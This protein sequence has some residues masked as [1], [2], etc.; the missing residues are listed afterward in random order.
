[1]LDAPTMLA[2]FSF[3]SLLLALVSVVVIRSIVTPMSAY[4]WTL[5][6]VFSAMSTAGGLLSGATDLLLPTP[7]G[8]GLSLLATSVFWAGVRR[9]YGA[10][11]PIVPASLI[12]A[13]GVGGPILSSVWWD[14][15][16]A[17]IIIFSAAQGTLLVLLG[18]DLILI[19]AR[20]S[21]GVWL[22]SGATLTL[23]AVLIV[24]SL[25][26]CFRIGEL[27]L[28]HFSG[29][30]GGLLL[31]RI[32]G[33]TGLYLGVILMTIDQ[34]HKRLTDKAYNDDLTELPNRRQFHERLETEWAHAVK[35]STSF[36]LLVIDLD[37]FKSINDTL[38]HAVGDTCL[39]HFARLARARLS[40]DDLIARTGGDE[41]C[42]I[43]P[44]V[45]NERAEVIADLLVESIRQCPCPAQACDVQM[46]ISVGIATWSSN[47]ASATELQALA[48]Q[49]LYL[50]K[51]RGRNDYTL[52]VPAGAPRRRSSMSNIGAQDHLRLEARSRAGRS[53]YRERTT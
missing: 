46:T 30:Q 32:C 26:A 3:N 18:L 15:A 48:D 47:V 7:I 2:V 27:S 6:A 13:V 44:N 14:D 43:L 19:A 38:G 51:R 5:S 10:H 16:T 41:F 28:V 36:A 24:H 23:T 25:A 50:S 42:V 49:A 31:A 9:F 12:I 8:N 34:F 1:M 20:R 40:T 33:T 17:E 21:P 53:K 52:S 45:D 22:A 29:V 4:L 39:I 37:D 35:C 11:F